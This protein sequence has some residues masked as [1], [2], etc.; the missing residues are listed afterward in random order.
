M[1]HH[2]KPLIWLVFLMPPQTAAGAVPHIRG[3]WWHFAKPLFPSFGET[4]EGP[5]V[6]EFHF[7]G[8]AQTLAHGLPCLLLQLRDERAPGQH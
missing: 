7:S 2:C 1:S 3:T 4:L 8:F 5:S 6:S